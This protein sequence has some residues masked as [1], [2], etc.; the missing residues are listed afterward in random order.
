MFDKEEYYKYSRILEIVSIVKFC[1]IVLVSAMI[2]YFWGEFIIKDYIIR[3]IIGIVIGIMLSYMS[4]IKEQ[5]K[6]EEMRMNIENNE[7]LKKIS[8]KIEKN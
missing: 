2:A 8:K 1:I 3:T 4:Y 7:E 5:I 6:I